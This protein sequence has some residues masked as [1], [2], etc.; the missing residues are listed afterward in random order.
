MNMYGLQTIVERVSPTLNFAMITPQ[1]IAVLETA[2]EL[3][4]ALV[5]RK[6]FECL[7][8]ASSDKNVLCR[9]VGQKYVPFYYKNILVEGAVARLGVPVDCSTYYALEYDYQEADFIKNINF[10]S[11][12]RSYVTPTSYDSGSWAVSGLNGF[13]TAKDIVEVISILKSNILKAPIAIWCEDF[14]MG[15]IKAREDYVKRFYQRYDFRYESFSWIP[16]DEVC[17]IDE[18]YDQ[19][20]QR[21]QKNKAGLTDLHEKGF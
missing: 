7:I 6:R 9:L 19:R 5:Y 13:C 11:I 10:N 21:R 17:Y 2:E 8:F 4:R 1:N 14:S 20:E 16:I 3:W 18:L 15:V 12:A